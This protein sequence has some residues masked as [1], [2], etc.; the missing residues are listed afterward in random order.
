M[1]SETLKEQYL[2]IAGANIFP[3]TK[4]FQLTP[5][6]SN[7]LMSDLDLLNENEMFSKEFVEAAQN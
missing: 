1:I 7:E 4:Q 5:K 3:Q 6:R 2:G